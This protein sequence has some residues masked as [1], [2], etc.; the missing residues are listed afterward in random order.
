MTLYQNFN[1]GTI[2]IQYFAKYH[3]IDINI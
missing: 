3:D 1:F 2:S